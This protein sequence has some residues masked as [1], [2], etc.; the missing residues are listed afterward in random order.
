MRKTPPLYRIEMWYH[1]ANEWKFGSWGVQL[2]TSLGQVNWGRQND[3]AGVQKSPLNSLLYSTQR[4][5]KNFDLSMPHN[6]NTLWKV[7][8]EK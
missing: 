6:T 7:S 2:Q 3:Q 4:R 8:S 5:K 1:G